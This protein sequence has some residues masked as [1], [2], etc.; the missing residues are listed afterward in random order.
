M[1]SSLRKSKR[2]NDNEGFDNLHIR[3]III[4]DSYVCIV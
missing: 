4:I 3:P 2:K 1:M